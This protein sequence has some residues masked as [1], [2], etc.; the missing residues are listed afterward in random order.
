VSSAPSSN[1]S[2]NWEAPLLRQ[3]AAVNLSNGGQNDWYTEFGPY[4]DNPA[5]AS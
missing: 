5:P 3:L 2:G 1:H 4:N